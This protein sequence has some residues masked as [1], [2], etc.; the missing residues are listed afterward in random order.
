MKLRL[1]AYPIAPPNPTRASGG[2]AQ[3]HLLG[4]SDL[5]RNDAKENF[6]GVLAVQIPF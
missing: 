6:L 1:P 2:P 4:E 3:Q 5:N